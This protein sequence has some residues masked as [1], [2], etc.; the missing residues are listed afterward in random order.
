MYSMLSIPKL[1]GV[2]D[3]NDPRAPRDLAVEDFGG[4]ILWADLFLIR[5]GGNFTPVPAS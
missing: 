1:K 3:V 4:N 2:V 5:N